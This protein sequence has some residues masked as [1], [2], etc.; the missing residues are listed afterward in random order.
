MQVGGNPGSVGFGETPDVQPDG[1]L[2]FAA[3]QYGFISQEGFLRYMSFPS[4]IRTII[5]DLLTLT[6]THL[7]CP[8]WQEF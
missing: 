2:L 5:G 3:P 6:R 1:T 8:L 7:K 4:M